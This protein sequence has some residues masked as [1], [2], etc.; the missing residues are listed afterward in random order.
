MG[1]YE[2][3]PVDPRL[4]EIELRVARQN[5]RYCFDKGIVPDIE[6][7]V[8]VMHSAY[9]AMTLAGEPL[10]APGQR[11]YLLSFEGAHSYVK[12][13]MV[14]TQTFPQR[15]PEYRREA[16]VGM[17]VIFDG[18]VSRPWPNARRWERRACD[19]IEAVPGVQKIGSERF[20][21]ITFEQA[22]EIVKAERTA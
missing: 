13:G 21:N 11:V 10:D 1:I 4:E 17:L 12:V 16:R 2:D 5:V 9:E 18:W 3:H 6:D 8:R 14:R 7:S 22:L 15:F 19:A 20:A